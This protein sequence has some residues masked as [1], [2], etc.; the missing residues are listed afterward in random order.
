MGLGLGK[1]VGSSEESSNYAQ[2]WC[3]FTTLICSMSNFHL[4][5]HDHLIEPTFTD[6]A[7][8]PCKCLA[9][10]CTMWHLQLS[11]W[12]ISMDGRHLNVGIWSGLPS[13]FIWHSPFGMESHFNFAISI[14][15]CL[16]LRDFKNFNPRQRPR[17]SLLSRVS[18]ASLWCFPQRNQ[19]QV[20]TL[21]Q[22]KEW[23]LAE[24]LIGGN[25][26]FYPIQLGILK[27]VSHAVG[28]IFS[29]SFWTGPLLGVWSSF[30]FRALTSGEPAVQ[31]PSTHSPSPMIYPKLC[32]SCST[33]C[34]CLE[35]TGK[36][37]RLLCFQTC[38]K[39]QRKNRSLIKTQQSRLECQWL[40]TNICSVLTHGPGAVVNSDPSTVPAWSRVSLIWPENNQPPCPL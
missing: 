10:C 2:A 36:L 15:F 35:L 11:Q 33:T 6:Q 37:F 27:T 29:C 13:L 8:V 14:L 23:H 20:A 21:G 31:S 5:G 18:T 39:V 22:A 19:T 4:G 17:G 1:M 7:G 40:L 32:S 3:T 9:A 38:L 26:I 34:L 28:P 24:S 12:C 30:V 16:I 25:H